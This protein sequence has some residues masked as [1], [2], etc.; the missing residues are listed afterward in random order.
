MR[1]KQKDDWVVNL[2]AASALALTIYMVITSMTRPA[3]VEAYGGHE[4]PAPR[5]SGIK[6][7]LKANL[8]PQ[9]DWF[10]RDPIEEL[11][12]A[13][14]CQELQRSAD[15][16]RTEK[17]LF[18]EIKGKVS[19]LQDEEIKLLIRLQAETE[20]HWQTLV[21]TYEKET[22]A[23]RFL[24]QHRPW[25]AMSDC[26]W[27][28]FKQICRGLGRN[29]GQ[30]VCSSKGAVGLMQFLPEIWLAFGQDGDGDGLASPWN[31]FDAM[32]TAAHFLDKN[33]YWKK[34]SSA[35]AYY[36]GGNRQ[37]WAAEQYT[38]DIMAKALKYG[39]EL[40]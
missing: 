33:G 18:R 1:T 2:G 32:T 9:P 34:P 35:V 27:T 15:Q 38:R 10:N 3:P 17:E 30:Q 19:C 4:Y 14:K 13:L 25:Q 29:P 23:G 28:A 36:V 8:P 31:W 6:A 22:L 40:N 24:G 37:S 12:L 39:A 7:E 16:R 5:Q 20:V 11:K 21:A 26:R